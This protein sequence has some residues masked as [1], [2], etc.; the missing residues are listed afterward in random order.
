MIVYVAIIGL[1]GFVLYRFKSY[2]LRLLN[3]GNGDGKLKRGEEDTRNMYDMEGGGYSSYGNQ[4][5]MEPPHV[6]ALATLHQG[7]IIDSLRQRF[8]GGNMN[9]HS[10]NQRMI[11]NELHH[12]HLPRPNHHIQQEVAPNNTSNHQMRQEVVPHNAPEDVEA[13]SRQVDREKVVPL[14]GIRGSKAIVVPAKVHVNSDPNYVEEDDGTDADSSSLW[15]TFGGTSEAT[16]STS[17]NGNGLPAIAWSEITLQG[18]I[19]GGAFGAVY[20]GQWR[21]TAVA[22]K[23]LNSACQEQLDPAILKAFTDEVRIMHSLRHPNVCLFM[24]VCMTAPNRAIVTELV[25]RGSLW[26]CLRKNETLGFPQVDS[27]TQPHWP[28]AAI[29][30][31][32]IGAL[33]GLAYLHGHVPPIIHRDMKSANL[34]VGDDLTIKICDFGLARLRDAS[35]YMT[36]HVGT[37]HW[38]APEVLNSQKYNERADMYSLGIIIWE[39]FTGKCPYEKMNQIEIAVNVVEKRMRPAYPPYLT[40]QQKWLL[41]V[42]LAYEPDT[43]MAADQILSYIDRIF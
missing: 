10:Y 19:G 5:V 32:V 1:V 35:I 12:A 18:N 8:Q 4:S 40:A 39:L 3:V 36:S 22:V 9:V 20:K 43:R 30:K 11:T 14:G 27:L 28:L 15:Q 24:A 41:D 17:L 38:M 29:K 2:F 31:V 26:D 37:V 7:N 23:L 16:E 6:A 21:S 13:A 42:C 25:S 34:L 33:Q